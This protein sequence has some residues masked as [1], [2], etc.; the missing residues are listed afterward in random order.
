LSVGE[1][2]VS[3][4]T[5]LVVPVRRRDGSAAVLKVDRPHRESEH[6]TAALAR[7]AGDGAVRLLAVDSGGDALLIERCEPGTPLAAVDPDAAVGILV[8]LLPR[9][10][11]PAGPPF[12]TL[13]DEAAHWARSLTDRWEGAG[14]PF[15]RRLLDAALEQMRVLAPS[16]EDRVLVHQDLHAGN[17]LRARREPWLVIDPKPLLAERAFAVAPIVRGPELGAGRRSVL[18]RLDRLTGELGL[19]RRRAAG[20]T[21]AQTVAWAFEGGSAL[22]HHVATARWV[23][24]TL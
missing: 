16:Q 1:P 14:R 15:E 6:E 2:F 13:D 23:L 7:W 18:R 20:W 5:A 4:G 24:D 8:D 21:L 17:V 10:W 9:L 19:D 11:T 22:A 12:R 3:S